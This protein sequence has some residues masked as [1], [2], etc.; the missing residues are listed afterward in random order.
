M[1]AETRHTRC[2]QRQIRA[3]TE[4]RCRQGQGALQHRHAGLLE[5]WLAQLEMARG[6]GAQRIGAEM[7]QF[8]K[9]A[10]QQ[11]ILPE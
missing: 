6:Q 7:V 8:S 3:R 2:A 5:R 4:T 1:L 10:R 9:L 11:K